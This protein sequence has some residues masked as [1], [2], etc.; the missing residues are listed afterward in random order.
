MHGLP[1]VQVL[2]FG[3]DDTEHLIC[4]LFVTSEEILELLCN[5]LSTIISNQLL[6]ETMFNEHGQV[7]KA[8]MVAL[9]I[10]LDTRSTPNHLDLASMITWKD[11]PWNG[12]Q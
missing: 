11:Q 12:P 1:Q 6:R 2:G 4:A 8:F 10:V 9:A 7:R 3:L 5:K